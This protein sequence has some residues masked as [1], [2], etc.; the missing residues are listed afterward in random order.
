MNTALVKHNDGESKN[1]QLASYSLFNDPAL[2]RVKNDLP[3]EVRQRYTE[4]GKRM[5]D[6][7]FTQNTLQDNDL[8]AMIDESAREIVFTLCNG[9][10]PSFLKEEEMDIMRETRGEKWYLR[11]GY[12]EEDLTEIVNTPKDLP[13]IEKTR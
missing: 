8:S 10:H 7:D 2:Q 5:Y 1:E 11:F 6:F 13:I 3:P 4:I 9:L 12:T